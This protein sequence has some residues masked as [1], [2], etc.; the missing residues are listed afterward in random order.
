MT[1]R[2]KT[3]LLLAGIITLSLGVTGYFYLQFLQQSLKHS[4]LA[5]VDAVAQTTSESIASFLDDSLRDAR[6]AAM[7]LP[8]PALEKNDIP[9]LENRLRKLV[10]T[11]PKFEN[12]MFILDRT[13]RIWVDYPPFPEVRGMDVSFREYFKRTMQEEKGIIGVPYISKRTGQPVLTFTAVLRGSDHQIL[14]ILGCS[15][16]ILSPSA[17]GGIRKTKIGKSGYIY[18]YD[19]SRLMILHPEDGRVLQ[20]DVPP[21]SNRLFDAAI[22]GFEGTGETVNSRGIAMLLSLKHIPGTDWI[23]GAQQ[24]QSDA[25]VPIAA[26]RRNILVGILLAVIASIGVGTIAVRRITQPLARLRQGALLLETAEHEGSSAQIKNELEGIRS[27]DEIGELARAFQDIFQKL[28]D[29]LISL[30]RASN[31]WERTFNTVPDLVA[32]I[33]GQDNIVR[34][35]QAMA[36]KL[37]VKVREAEGLKCHKLFQD[38]STPAASPG[39][40]AEPGENPAPIQELLQKKLG[41]DFL[42]TASPLKGPEGE[43][44][45]AVY[46]ARDISERRRAEEE[47]G[48]LEAQMREVQKL[49]SLGVLAGGIAHDFN[50]LLM[51]ILGN[52]DLALLSLSPASPARPQIEEISRA[53]QRAADLCR[54]MLAYS[55]KGR[56][57]IGRYDLSE[58]VREMAQML[59][60][61]VSKKATLRYSF[62]PELPAVEADATQLRQVIMN[63]ITNASESLGDLSGVI[64]V[65]TG[66]ME[67]DRAYLADSHLDDRL[68]EGR[69]VYLEVADTGSGMDEETRRRIFDPFFTTKFTGRG[70]GLAVVLGIV[71]G[72]HGAIKFY[73]EPGKGTNFKILFPAV[74]WAPAD[75][76]ASAVQT[77]PLAQGGTVL[78]VDD[79]AKVRQVGSQML[80]I[81]G[82]QVLAAATGQEA[83]EAFQKGVNEIDCV[84]LDLTM[85]EMGGEE[86]FRQLRQLRSDVCVI[87]SSGYNEQ[88][89]TQRFVG[90]GLAGFIQKPY[91]MANLQVILNRVLRP[92]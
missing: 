45:G 69:Y 58:I 5:G 64:S 3:S 68:P 20:R 87:L 88:E 18:V 81:L 70:L 19:K 25:Y 24:L 39:L 84:I 14:G 21:G 2:T 82:F 22:Q 16:Q 9:T 38:F 57:V 92:R 65:T 1:L 37:G 76:A 32:I 91:T 12:G 50:N 15:V 86:V 61:S 59:E 30:R 23:I 54:Q 51:A 7:A 73:S 49:E 26:A 27:R 46:V 74:A 79:D 42:L 83:L 78:L 44:L 10:E 11:F 53:S 17:L 90:K 34:V 89:V 13:G 4:I 43:L 55:G 47:R 33:D 28:Q 63:L 67:C 71:R 36:A 60:V 72:H 77:A 52:A 6:V 85:P 75:R 40:P 41:Q 80:T 31:D 35:N 48:K 29:T 8:V 56:F 66:V 62:A